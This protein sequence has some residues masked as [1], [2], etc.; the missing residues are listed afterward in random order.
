MRFMILI[1]LFD[2][3][4]VLNNKMIHYT[5]NDYLSTYNLFTAIFYYK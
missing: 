4:Q 3:I 5:K 2:F 1:K